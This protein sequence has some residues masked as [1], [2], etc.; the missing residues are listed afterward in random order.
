MPDLTVTLSQP[1]YN[2]V[3]QSLGRQLHED[4]SVA[5]D[6][7]IVAYLRNALKKLA[8]DDIRLDKRPAFVQAMHNQF[9]GEGWDD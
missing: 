7:E 4:G 1:Q 5:T 9:R 6:A 2:R 8:M 3:S